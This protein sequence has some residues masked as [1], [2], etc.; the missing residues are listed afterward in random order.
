MQPVSPIVHSIVP[1]PKRVSTNPLKAARR[2]R[3]TPSV[4]MSRARFHD[5]VEFGLLFRAR[6]TA[7]DWARPI[8]QPRP[9]QGVAGGKASTAIGPASSTITATGGS[10][11][12]AP[13]G[14]RRR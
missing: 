7:M 2:Q 8:Q 14:R 1:A 6:Q 10:S 3:T 12:H 4:A 9:R 13:A 11:P 5:Q